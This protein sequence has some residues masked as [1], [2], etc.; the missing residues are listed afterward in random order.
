MGILTTIM[1]GVA[2]R[3]ASLANPDTWLEQSF[4]AVQTASG[5]SVDEAKALTL[6]AVYACVRVLSETMA[7]L[8]LP[9]YRRLDPRGKERAPSH[10]LYPILHDRPNPEMTAFT[11]KE[12][13]MSHVILWGNAYAEIELDRANRVIALWPLLPDRTWPERKNKVLRYHTRVG[14]QEVTLPPE[15]VLHIPGLSF[16]G[17]RGYSPIALHRQAVGLGLAGEEFGSRFFGSGAHMGGVLEFDGSF[18]D[19]DARDDFRRQ[20][21]AVHQGLGNAHLTPV[22]EKGMTWTQTSIPPDDAQ[23]LE[24]RQFQ[25][26]EIARIFRVPPHLIADLDNATFSNIEHQSL[27]FVIYS[28]RP[29]LVRFEQA[30]NHSL[31][32]ARERAEVFVEFLIDALLRG[33][34]AARFEAYT[35]GR[36]NGWLSANDIRDLENMNPLPGA[37][38]DVYMVPLNMVDAATF[39]Q[40]A[41]SSDPGPESNSAPTGAPRNETRSV[42]SRRRVQK[43]HVP[44]LESAARRTIHVEVQAVARA[45]KRAHGPGGGGDREFLDWLD[46]FYRD[47]E[48]TIT[49]QMLPA[50]MT[51]AEA[52]N[53]EANA[54]I[55]ADEEMTSEMGDFVQSY[56]GS[57]AG[58]MATSSAGQLRRLIIELDPV[59]AREAV[60]RRL[61]E[62]EETR[63]G[64]VA[65]RESVQAGSAIAK[66]AWAAAGVRRLVWRAS[67][68]HC[69]ICEEM[70]GKTVEITRTFVSAGQAVNPEGDTAPLEATQSFGHPPLHEGCNCSIEPG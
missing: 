49:R 35:K 17:L 37:Q 52:I 63:P 68:G 33:D 32:P 46:E 34:T 18:E 57:L 66:A 62:W 44:L 38:G 40:G 13:L 9:V 36:M 22:L 65:A 29:W 1:N 23:F 60:T 54:E 41:G 15:R 7:S 3:R 16:D 11:F 27:E 53:A 26:R 47:H 12:T 61:G 2:E 39:V 28:L 20:F 69:P 58:R 14:G 25:V 6:S 10:S 45:L 19:Q 21:A 59:K 31:I 70:D 24:T 67:A 30:L 8:P 64:K 56:A 42:A 55:G 51:L 50:L 48:P 43:A 5:V 4:G